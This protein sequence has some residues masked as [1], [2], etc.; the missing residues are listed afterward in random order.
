MDE[1]FQDLAIAIQA[2]KNMNKITLLYVSAPLW[3]D[4]KGS[5]RFFKVS[6]S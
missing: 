3:I 2:A 4:L 6:L 1:D 5:A